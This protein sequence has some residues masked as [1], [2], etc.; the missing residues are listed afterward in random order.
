MSL[1]AV[2]VVENRFSVRLHYLPFRAGFIL[3]ICF[4]LVV[5]VLLVGCFGGPAADPFLPYDAEVI[6]RAILPQCFRRSDWAELCTRDPSVAVGH[7]EA[8]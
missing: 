2:G 1:L 3:L 4:G 7:P 5:S 6:C 8:Y